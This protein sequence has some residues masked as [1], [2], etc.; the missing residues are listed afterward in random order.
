MVIVGRY[1]VSA[2]ATGITNT[3]SFILTNQAIPTITT[4]PSMTAVT[5]GTSPVT[6]ND[7]AVLSDGYYETGSITFTLLPGQHAGGYRDGASQ[8]RRHVHDADR[9][10][11]AN[12]GHRDRDLPVGRQLQRRHLQHPGERERHR[13]RAGRREPRRPDDHHDAEHHRGH[14]WHVA[15]DLERHRD[16]SRAA[17]TR[18]ARSRSRSTWAARWWIPRP[19][20]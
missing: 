17:I 7:T 6:L 8:R 19:C 10:Y 2:G 11:V 15:G 3:A 5:L 1:T 12:D 14:A 20:R 13:G 4:T 16:C 18:R 9:L